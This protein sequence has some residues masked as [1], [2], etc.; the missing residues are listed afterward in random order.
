MSG[1]KAIL[2]AIAA[3]A[4]LSAQ[5]ETHIPNTLK[6]RNPGA[7]VPVWKKYRITVDATDWLVNGAP[8]PAGESH[9]SAKSASTTQVINLFQL[10]A[11]G[12][13]EG[14][15]V[16]RSTACTGATTAQIT[17]IGDACGANSY[18]FTAYNLHTV[19]TN[20]DMRHLPVLRRCTIVAAYL[21][22]TVSTTGGN[23]N[24]LAN[25]VVDTWVKWSILP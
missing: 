14:I 13:V 8:A 9:V 23:V 6:V 20:T 11:G 16:R 19:P 2:L 24:D 15:A 21:Y 5:V 17:E 4:A 18:G 1:I 3:A 7:N 10:P 22:I 12:I 25:C